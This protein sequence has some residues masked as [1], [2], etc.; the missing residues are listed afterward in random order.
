MLRRTALFALSSLLLTGCVTYE[1]VERRVY[2]EDG[3]YSRVY[4]PYDDGR[5][6]EYDERGRYGDRRYEYDRY[7][8]NRYGS[9]YDDPYDR[10]FY[11]WRGDGYRYGYGSTYDP[12]FGYGGS[13]ITIIYGSGSRWGSGWHRPWY[14]PSW[15]SSSWHGGYSPWGYGYGHGYSHGYRPSR[16]YR[17]HPQTPHPQEPRPMPKP[18]ARSVGPDVAMP[19][20]VG[21]NIRG[22]ALRPAPRGRRWEEPATRVVQPMPEATPRAKPRPVFVDDASI[23]GPIRDEPRFE[24]RFERRVEEP[25]FEQPRFERRV[26]EPRFEQ[27]SYEEPR[28]EPRREDRADPVIREDVE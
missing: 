4:D 10:W 17:P 13:S 6:Y 12:W 21:P 27:P 28:F 7:D 25:R 18:A 5:R 8:G 23:G 14:G 22:E 26:E 24:P 19:V 3:S 16:P 15:Y 1:V 20:I 11:G 2:H 9:V